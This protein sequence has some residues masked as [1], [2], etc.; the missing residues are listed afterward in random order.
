[1]RKPLMDKLIKEV[2]KIT[3]NGDLG[4]RMML[5][6]SY[7]AGGGVINPGTDTFSSPDVSQNPDSFD[8]NGSVDGNPD[9]YKNI[10]SDDSNVGPPNFQY[11]SDDGVRSDISI[12][13]PETTVTPNSQTNTVANPTNYNTDTQSHNLTD[14]QAGITDI[15]YKVTPDEVIEGINAELH[16]MVF[17]RPDVAKA[18][19]I[20]NLKKDPK[21]YSKL[22]F[23]NIDDTLDESF[24]NMTPQQIA[25]A[26]IVR[27]MKSVNDKKR[28]KIF[29]E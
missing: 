19:V 12:P 26:K 14:T 22:K 20:K 10:E 1:M 3:E 8:L 23:L 15:K 25:M 24:K 13:I 5:G 17:K 29:Y 11:A 27:N 16:D 21:Y 28:R 4:D 18:L 2:G 7:S 6:L 9:A